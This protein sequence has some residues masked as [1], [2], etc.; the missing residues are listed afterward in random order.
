MTHYATRVAAYEDG[1]RDPDPNLGDYRI[2]DDPV[3]PL[4]IPTPAGW[5]AEDGTPSTSIRLTEA[6]NKA[7]CLGAYVEMFREANRPGRTGQPPRKDQA[8]TSYSYAMYAP[9]EGPAMADW[10]VEQDGVP[11]ERVPDEARSVREWAELW[12]EERGYHVTV[13]MRGGTEPDGR[14]RWHA[15]VSRIRTAAERRAL[16]ERRARREGR[17]GWCPSGSE[18]VADVDIQL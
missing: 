2:W 10:R 13:W 14:L 9:A 3:R 5:L 16:A 18:V 1:W 15:G 11:V 4:D 17:R 12:I 8:M 6:R 7:G